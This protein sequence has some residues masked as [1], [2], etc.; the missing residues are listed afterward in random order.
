MFKYSNGE[1][2]S[3]KAMTNYKKL[4]G[5]ISVLGV[6]AFALATTWVQPSSLVSVASG[7][8]I[9]GVMSV[10]HNDELVYIGHNAM[11]NQGKGFV[12]AALTGGMAADAVDVISLGNGSGVFTTNT[13]L[14][15]NITDCGLLAVAGTLNLDSATPFT[16]GANWSYVNTFT[17]SCNNELVNASGMS[18]TTANTFMWWADNFTATTLQSSDT[19]RITWNISVN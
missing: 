9:D 5:L 6:F 7:P 11:M 12:R 8:H 10:E 13:S 3:M 2:N 18:N 1:S 19:L 17:S 16:G 14:S 15:G 4:F